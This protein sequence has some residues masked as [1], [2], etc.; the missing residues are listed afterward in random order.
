[1]SHQRRSIFDEDELEDVLDNEEVDPLEGDE[2]EPEDPEDPDPYKGEEPSTTD[3]D[4]RLEPA[5]EE[6]STASVDTHPL[7]VPTG[8]VLN[9]AAHTQTIA[10]FAALVKALPKGPIVQTRLSREQRE[11]IV[12]VVAFY[13]DGRR[14]IRS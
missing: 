12:A 3:P 5:D 10:R 2:G 7:R 4:E 13:K 6:A 11:N 1:M 9:K 8:P 14:E